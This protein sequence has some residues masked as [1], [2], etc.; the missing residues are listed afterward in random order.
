MNS[1]HFSQANGVH[2]VAGVQQLLA[3]L[4]SGEP[5]HRLARLAAAALKA[6]GA[7]FAV[8]TGAQAHCKGAAGLPESIMAT[9][10]LVSASPFLCQL[11]GSGKP[12]AVEHAA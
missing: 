7:L 10:G 11:V 5:F 3:D 2:P 4:P 6:P 12:L 8:V 9:G 1:D